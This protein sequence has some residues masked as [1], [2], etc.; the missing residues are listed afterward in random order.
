MKKYSFLLLIVC[1]SATTLVYA[2][3]A[4]T[5]RLNINIRDYC[6]PATFNAAIGDG[7]C[8]RDTSTGAITFS[9]FVAEATTDKSVGAWRFAPL[10]TRLA[11]GTRMKI[12]NLGGELHTF[13]RVEHFGGGFVDFLNQATGN[14]KPAP[15]CAKMVNGNLV[16][17][18]RSPENLFIAPGASA[19]KFSSSEGPV[20]YQCCIHP[21]MR[22]TVSSSAP[23]STDAASEHASH[24]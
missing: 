7:T 13:T 20:R 3:G 2:Q 6:D 21:W 1:L 23:A 14:P 24:Q 19:T 12:T 4:P 11:P 8:V 9:G 18:P 15:E 16:P 17:Q 22:I 10:S 5:N